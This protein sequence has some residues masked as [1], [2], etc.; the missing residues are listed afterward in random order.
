VALV[1]NLGAGFVAARSYLACL[2]RSGMRI[3]YH[4]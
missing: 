4:G 1:L 3:V 2:T